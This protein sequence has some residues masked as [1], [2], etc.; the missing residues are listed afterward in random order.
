MPVWID[1]DEVRRY[2]LKEDA[3]L[4]EAPVFLLGVPTAKDQDSITSEVVAS[5]NDGADKVELGMGILNLALRVSLRGWENWEKPDGTLV[6]FDAKD[7]E[8]SLT[9]L[10]PGSRSELGRV[11]IEMMSLGKRERD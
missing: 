10:S 4:A 5:A 2:T 11:A 1:P 7:V 3:E 6:E 9:M 8:R